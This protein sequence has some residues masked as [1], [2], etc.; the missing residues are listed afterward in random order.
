MTIKKSTPQWVKAPELLPSNSKHTD[1]IEILYPVCAD[2]NNRLIGPTIF[3]SLVVK[4]K[5]LSL[6][7]WLAKL[8][9]DAPESERALHKTIMEWS[10]NA[11]EFYRWSHGVDSGLYGMSDEKMGV[12][13]KN[14]FRKSI[15]R[16]QEIANK[17]SNYPK[18]VMWAWMWI[19]Y[20]YKDYLK[21]PQESIK[22]YSKVAESTIG[23][24]EIKMA[25]LWHMAD[26]YYKIRDLNNE[27]KVYQI[28]ITDY[29]E[30]ENDWPYVSMAKERLK[31]KASK[32]NEP[33]PN[34][35]SGTGVIGTDH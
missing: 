20:T 34:G 30:T 10:I 3:D 15:R 8:P 26:C 18:V 33:S 23:E 9:S 25:A 6:C 29:K 5:V 16:F 17:Y 13:I 1:G 14:N 2:A 28:I 21:K 11:G 22:W 19:G 12:V 4:E 27:K 35:V 24:K 31:I 7:K 32:S